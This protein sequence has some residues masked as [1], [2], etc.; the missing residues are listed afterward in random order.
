MDLSPTPWGAKSRV[1]CKN[2]ALTCQMSVT[3]C[4]DG[5]EGGSMDL[6]PTPWGAATRSICTC[7]VTVHWCFSCLSLFAG[8]GTEG[9]SM[10]LS[11]TPWGA[12]TRSMC[13]C[14]IVVIRNSVFNGKTQL[15]VE[16]KLSLPIS[17]F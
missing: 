10:D 6:S 8:N 1:V 5:T 11:P 3:V 17:F 15:I 9:G 2:C 4:R 14:V 16:D 12:A 13:T 7:V